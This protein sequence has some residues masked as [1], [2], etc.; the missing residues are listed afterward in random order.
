M[1]G[2]TDA[3]RERRQRGDS[4][5]TASAEPE[6]GDN[7]DDIITISGAPDDDDD[8]E[9]QI[10]LAARRKRAARN[11]SISDENDSDDADFELGNNYKRLGE[12][13]ECVQCGNTF[14][15]TV[16]SRFLDA[17]KG[18]LCDSCNE[19]VKKRERNARR[20]QLSA[21]RKRK[22]VAEALLDKKT[23]RF[24]TLQDLCIRKITANIADVEVLGDIGQVNMNK[25]S[26][27]LSRNRSLD[28]STVALFL[29]PGLKT[30]QFW[31]CSNVD[32]DALNKIASFCPNLELLTLYM[33]G[34]L[35]ND[36]L[37]YFS[38]QLSLQ[39]LC[40]NGPFLISDTMWQD[41]F[42]AGG[43]KLARF[44][45]RNTHRFGNDSLISLLE[46]CGKNLTLLKLS[47]LDGITS[48][49][50]LELIPHYVQPAL[51][52]HFELSYPF[53]E[54][55]VTDDLLVNLL[56]VT[57][58]SLTHLNLDLCSN[59]TDRFLHEGVMRF[60]PRLTHLSIKG[61]DQLT[62]DGVAMAF[63]DYSAVNG[64]G[65]ISL[66]ISKCENLGNE[67]LHAIL[68]HSGHTLVELQ[69]NLVYGLTKDFFMQ[70]LTEDLHPS[71]KKAENTES[72]PFY[73]H[74]SFPLL[75]RWDAGFVRAVD[76]EVL[77]LVSKNCS[78][79]AYVEVYGNNKCTSKARVRD[80]LLIIGRQSDVI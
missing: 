13:D 8:E 50:V 60:C 9:V 46:N 16:Y 59:L 22:K 64:G 56:S 74:V 7:T 26:Q 42:E 30:L 63:S 57:G 39:E 66:D 10:R 65:L 1:E 3:F 44:E 41:F 20:N 15:V 77:S 36:N 80:D 18:Y 67:A 47:R 73:G 55:L 78:K 69:T 31:D 37:S 14:S 76:D 40:L 62:N 29:H 79:L 43:S 23:V 58:E 70:I 21:R 24:P 32:S 25:I 52:T 45:V 35:H 51:L 33:C 49:A 72:D 68:A 11:G 12:D 34:Q 61:L 75:T 5:A 2:I 53:K 17:K 19:E 27:I 48:G 28:S 71:K 38:S 4:S 54:D 6:S